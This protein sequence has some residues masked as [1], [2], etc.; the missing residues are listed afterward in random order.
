[1]SK[2]REPWLGNE[3]DRLDED[4]KI[5]KAMG[6][7]LRDGVKDIVASVREDLANERAARKSEQG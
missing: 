1:M 6:R 5:L 3:T 4:I 2:K 7:S